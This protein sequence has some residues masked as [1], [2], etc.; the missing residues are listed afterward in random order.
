MR[1]AFKKNSHL[2][3]MSRF[4]ET[5]AVAIPSQSTQQF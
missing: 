4:A 1:A 3:S 2:K 5:K